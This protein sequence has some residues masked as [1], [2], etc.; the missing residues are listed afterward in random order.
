M[1]YL[2][3]ERPKPWFVAQWA[4]GGRDSSHSECP[5][6]V[7]DS[8]FLGQPQPLVETGLSDCSQALV[9]HV[10]DSLQIVLEITTLVG[11]DCDPTSDVDQGNCRVARVANADWECRAVKSVARHS[12]VLQSGAHGAH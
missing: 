12:V 10:G 5:R 6:H 7:D 1:G 2:D 4:H 11:I 8:G 9:G 3:G